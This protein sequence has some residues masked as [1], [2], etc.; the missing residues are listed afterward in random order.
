VDLDLDLRIGNLDLDLDLDLDLAVAGLVT[1]L[2]LSSRTV[3]IHAD[4]EMHVPF[5]WPFFK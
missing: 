4:K 1:S 3:H 5:Q 2:F